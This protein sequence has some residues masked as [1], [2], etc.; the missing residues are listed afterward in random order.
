MK[1]NKR[2]LKNKAMKIKLSFILL[3][4]MGINSYAQKKGLPEGWTRIQQNGKRAYK[5]LV[6]GKISKRYPKTPALKPIEDTVFDPTIIHVVKEGETL[7]SIAK[8]YSFDIAKLHELNSFSK[9]KIE[10]GEEV[11]LGYAHNQQEKKA[12]YNGDVSVLNH[13][14][15]HDD[16]YGYYDKTEKKN[17]EFKYHI[18]LSG[19]TLYR[20]AMNYKLSVEELKKL[21]N[22]K[23]ATIMVGQKLRVK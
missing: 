17:V 3:L 4:L 14:H 5:N 18:V 7:I 22:L 13:D 20:V 10:V 8:K 16:D 12:F 11:I 23:K 19:E 21:N 1:N 2:G 6:T 15:D 9:S